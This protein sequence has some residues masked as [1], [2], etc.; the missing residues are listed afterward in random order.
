MRL[1]LEL[2]CPTSRRTSR[3]LT[4]KSP[5][6]LRK[7]CASLGRRPRSGRGKA[8]RVSACPLLDRRIPLPRVLNPYPMENASALLIRPSS[9]GFWSWVQSHSWPPTGQMPERPPARAPDLPLGQLVGTDSD[10]WRMHLFPAAATS[11]QESTDDC[12]YNI[13]CNTGHDSRIFE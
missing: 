3:R 4:R 8:T 10:A 11:V 12:A 6:T 2:L 7:I 1:W 5:S 13:A 9:E